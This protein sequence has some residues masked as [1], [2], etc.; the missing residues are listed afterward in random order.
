MI[1]RYLAAKEAE[2]RAEE[3]RLAVEAEL[4]Q[5]LAEHQ[6]EEG[7]KTVEA[8]GYKITLTQRISRKL[9]EKAWALVAD[10]IPMS[11]SPIAKVEAYKIDDA[12]CRWLKTNE[13]GLW[14]VLSKALTEK[15]QKIGVKVQEVKS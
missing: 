8:D 14:T 3:N 1:E 10:A 7:S 6:P 5:A 9:D 11:V 13:P 2:D 12:G 4:V 15:P